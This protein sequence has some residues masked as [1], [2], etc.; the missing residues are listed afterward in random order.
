MNNFAMIIRAL[1]SGLLLGFVVSIPLGPAGLEAVKRTMTSGFKNGLLV[2][3]GAVTS[4]TLD[5]FLINF[6]LFNLINAN[7]KTEAVVWLICGILLA[8]FGYAS[9]YNVK[10][11]KHIEE[12]KP[13]KKSAPFLTGFAMAFSNPMVHSMWL[14]LSGTVIRV[15]RGRGRTAYY[16]YI[17]SIIVAMVTWFIILNMLALKGHNKIKPTY[18]KIISLI[19]AWGIFGIGIGFIVYGGVLWIKLYI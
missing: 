13:K 3:L 9:V 12:N 17:I 15:W 4:D 11:E 1:I 8:A 5:I 7:K 16:T 10:H 14:T 2:S 19:I 18:S 6:G